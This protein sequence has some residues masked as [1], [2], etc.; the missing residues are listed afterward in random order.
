M[1]SDYIAVWEI[2]KLLEENESMIPASLK[3]GEGPAAN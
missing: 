2:D 1:D 3:S